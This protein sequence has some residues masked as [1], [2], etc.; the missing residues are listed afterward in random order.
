DKVDIESILQE[1]K[2]QAEKTHPNLTV[3]I[4]T[5]T[6]KTEILGA[7]LIPIVFDNLMRNSAEYAKKDVTLTIEITSED[8]V[9]FVM[10]SDDG[11]GIPKEIESKLFEKGASTTGGGLGLYLTKKVI[12]GYGGKIEYLQYKRLPGTTFR[13]QLPAKRS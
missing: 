1:C 2:S 10:L 13:I 12:E 11:P 5:K 6:K 8:D 7:R 3:N 9:V 4:K